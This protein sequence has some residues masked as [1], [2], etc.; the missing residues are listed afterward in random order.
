MNAIAL[1]YGWKGYTPEPVQV[2]KLSPEALKGFEGRFR[3]GSDEALTVKLEG[4]RLTG[5]G[6]G[7]ESFELLPVA[8]NEFVRRDQD[9]RYVFAPDGALTIRSPR[10]E[11]RAERMAAGASKLI[12]V[13]PEQSIIQRYDGR[14]VVFCGLLIGAWSMYIMRGFTLE[15]AYWDFVWPRIILGVGLAM[16]FVPLTTVT[17]ATIEK[18]EMGNATGIFNLLRNVGG[19]VGIAIAATL[20]SR[21]AQFYQSS[22]VS[23]VNPYNPV[24]RDRLTGLKQAAMSRGLDAVTAD[25][26]AIAAI[27]GIVRRQSAM[28]AYN[29]IFWV[30]GIAFLIIIPCLLLLKKPKHHAPPAGLH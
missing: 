27:Y 17:L 23:Q 10:R 5:K 26:T 22:L 21:Y 16:I 18:E 9:V 1:T 25:K 4:G 8:A 14:K 3:L 6:V 28:L 19:S 13:L 20:L 15:A 11:I 7:P 30:V 12:L 24:A 2:I 29:R